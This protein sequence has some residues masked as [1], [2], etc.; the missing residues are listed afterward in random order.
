[1]AA[2]ATFTTSNPSEMMG[3]RGEETY[4]ARQTTSTGAG[5][6]GV[7]SS[8][9][10]REGG[11]EGSP[12]VV[13]SAASTGREASASE[14]EQRRKTGR[15]D[16]EAAEREEDAV[17]VNPQARACETKSLLGSALG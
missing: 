16:V 2:R 4:G 1:M 14:L 17:D 15:R 8:S 11:R 3:S 9:G 7:Y 12:P 6:M 10:A 13:V 5:G